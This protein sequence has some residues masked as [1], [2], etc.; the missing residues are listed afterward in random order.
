MVADPGSSEPRTRRDEDHPVGGHPVTRAAGVPPGGPAP[1]VRLP[2]SGREVAAR[3][4][5]RYRAGV[6]R[7][8]EMF[9]D[10]DFDVDWIVVSGLP[11]SGKT[12]VA[13]ILN[14]L[15]G[16]P[17]LSKDMIKESLMDSSTSIDL[18]GSRSIG[19]ASIAVMYAV[20]RDC[21]HAIL[22]SVWDR[23]RSVDDINGLGGRVLEVFCACDPRVAHDRYRQRQRHPG[24]L[25]RQRDGSGLWDSDRA[26]PLAAGWPVVEI[27]TDLATPDP[28]LVDRV[29]SGLTAERT[30]HA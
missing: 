4:R 22:E 10:P 26:A 14:H 11:G 6:R 21:G 7:P 2:G 9:E 29:R 20:A 8:P 13:R 17:L 24:H 27:R 15:T 18:A 12:T 25:D 28:G 1:R 5:S 19:I 16:F 23:S 3:T 30:G